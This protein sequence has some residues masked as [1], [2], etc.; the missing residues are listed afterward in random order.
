MDWQSDGQYVDVLKAG[1]VM[2][3]LLVSVSLES[4]RMWQSLRVCSCPIA[5]SV[6]LCCKLLHERSRNAIVCSIAVSEG[7]IAAAGLCRGS[8]WRFQVSRCCDRWTRC[9]LPPTCAASIMMAWA[10][11]AI[12]CFCNRSSAFEGA[13]VNVSWT[14]RRCRSA[15]R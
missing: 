11:D 10:Y 15:G 2:S 12:R 14:N 13:S 9:S 4:W 5:S 1:L 6:L 7:C 3:G 8:G